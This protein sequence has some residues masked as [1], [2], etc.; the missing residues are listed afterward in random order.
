M[1]TSIIQTLSCVPLVSVL[2]RSNCKQVITVGVREHVS[3]LVDVLKGFIGI[4]YLKP[5][6]DLA[7][8]VF[9]ERNAS[10]MYRRFNKGAW[11]FLL[12]NHLGL[13]CKF[14]GKAFQSFGP[15]LAKERSDIPPISVFF[16][17]FFLFF[18]FSFF[19]AIFYINYYFL[20]SCL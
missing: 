11:I 2:K 10:S 16:L 12:R 9:L 8:T 17:F 14:S 6:V 3:Q 7:T 15:N 20:F 19:I 4:H 13:E 1:D 18:S 5:A